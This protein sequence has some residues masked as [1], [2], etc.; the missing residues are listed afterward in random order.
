VNT[1]EF[2]GIVGAGL[3]FGPG[4]VEL[5]YDHGF[6]D[7]DDED[8]DSSAKSRTVSIVVGFGWR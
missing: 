4:M 2:S 5:R 6:N 1:F 7:L 3:Q 8:E